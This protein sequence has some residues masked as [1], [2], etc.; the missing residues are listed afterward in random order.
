MGIRT[1]GGEIMDLLKLKDDIRVGEDEGLGI[2]D[3]MNSVTQQACRAPC[4]SP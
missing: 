1:S 3:L 2:R 4:E